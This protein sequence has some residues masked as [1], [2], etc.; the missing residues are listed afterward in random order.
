MCPAVAAPAPVIKPLGNVSPGESCDD[1]ND[2]EVKASNVCGVAAVSC[3][4]LASV[5]APAEL[6]A[7]WVATAI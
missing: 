3:D 1:P 4:M 7:D 2:P 6:M 5:C